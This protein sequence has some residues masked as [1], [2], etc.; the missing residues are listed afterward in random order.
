MFLDETLE[1]G[2]RM[3][4]NEKYTVGTMLECNGVRGKVV[5]NI[6]LPGDI[7]VEWD[8]VAWW[9]IHSYDADWLDDN[10]IIIKSQIKLNGD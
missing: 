8:N 1:H 5:E 3:T 4:R 6:K 9:P 2:Y 7:C 10:V